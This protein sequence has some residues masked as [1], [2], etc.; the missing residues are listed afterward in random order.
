MRKTKPPR[1]DPLP[2][3]TKESFLF[4]LVGELGERALARGR[5]PLELVLAGGGRRVFVSVSVSVS[6]GEE[7]CGELCEGGGGLELVLSQGM[8]KS[9]EQSCE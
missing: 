4:E 3:L 7:S 8:R 5:V 2:C 9:L 6:I 1:L